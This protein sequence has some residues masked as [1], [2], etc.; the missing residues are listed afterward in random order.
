MAEW[1]KGLQRNRRPEPEVAGQVVRV[2]ASATAQRTVVRVIVPATAPVHTVGRGRSRHT[3]LT[4]CIRT[5]LVPVQTP[6][7]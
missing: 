7:P 4:T 6:L 1:E 2:A 5:T 3:I